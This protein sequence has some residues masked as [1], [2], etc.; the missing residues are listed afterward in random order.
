MAERPQLSIISYA[1]GAYIIVEGKQD[2]SKFFII[3]RG[4]VEIASVSSSM[5]D[6][7]VHQL[8]PG[9]FFGVVSAMSGHIQVETARAITDVLLV[10][11][12]RSQFEG[13]IQFNTPVAMKIIQQFSR[14]VRQLNHSLTLITMQGKNDEEDNDILFKNAQYYQSRK[15]LHKAFYCYK[16]YIECYPA[17]RSTAK[18]AEILK[19]LEEHNKPASFPMSNSFMRKYPKDNLLCAEGERGAEMYIIQ[20]GTANITQIVNN[21]EVV[22][23]TLRPGDMFGEMALLE[24]KPR[25]ASAVALEDCIVMVVSKQNFESM[26]E[27]KPQIIARLTQ[28]LADRIW[29]SYKKLA[30]SG[31][32]DPVARFFDV[33]CLQMEKDKIPLE[34]FT[35]HIFNYNIDQFMKMAN[36]PNVDKYNILTI[37]KKNQMLKIVMDKLVTSDVMEIVKLAEFHKKRVG[38][39]MT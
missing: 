34:P 6:G 15:E 27:T 3:Q 31:I 19:S 39:R 25:S 32:K 33:L 36:I 35:A 1:Q 7:D 23:A 17:A 14:R 28:M 8:G 2:I 20:S 21:S 26:A 22:L 10:S 37:I 30:N 13:L 12:D 38:R 4:T 5:I 24:S 11:V 18:A 29:F 9:D 16:R